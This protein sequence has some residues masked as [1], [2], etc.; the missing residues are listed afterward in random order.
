MGH[1]SGSG[2]Q[3]NRSTH[4]DVAWLQDG[5]LQQGAPGRRA[6]GHVGQPLGDAFVMRTGGLLK[7]SETVIREGYG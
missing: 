1:I 4:K 6:R 3:A 7:S 2:S 5:D